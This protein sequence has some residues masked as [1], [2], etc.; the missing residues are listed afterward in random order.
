MNYTKIGEF[1]SNERKN[2]N[3]S[4]SQLAEMLFISYKT[5]S[6]WET[7]RGLPDTSVLPRLCEILDVSI[8]ELLSGKRLDQ[9]HYNKHAEYNI[10][11]LLEHARFDYSVETR[12]KV[13][14]ISTAIQAVLGILAIT[15]MLLFLSMSGLN[16]APILA[17]A[18]TITLVVAYIA[19]IIIVSVIYYNTSHKH[20]IDKLFLVVSI[21]F[22]P[23]CALIYA[24]L[25]PI[26]LLN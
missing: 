8:N 25:I 21:L 19:Q 3:I 5:V 11:R 6:K 16:F 20:K 22:L 14:F 24:L 26:V 1:I 17:I 18:F 7:G 13:Y 4:Q 9:Q 23:L 12:K 10:S 15:F 2:K